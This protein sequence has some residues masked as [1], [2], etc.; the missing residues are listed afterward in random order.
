MAPSALTDLDLAVDFFERGAQLSPR[1]K[2][3]LVRS[4]SASRPPSP[5]SRSSIFI[6]NAQLW[7]T[8]RDPT[9]D[10]LM[11]FASLFQPILRNLKERALRAFNQYRN[12]H[13][14]PSLDIQLRIGPEDDFQDE[15]AIFGGQTRVVTN[16]FLSRKK[17]RI[18]AKPREASATTVPLS[19]PATSAAST[20]AP[21]GASQ[22]QSAA[23]PALT[24]STPSD[25]GLPLPQNVEEQMSNVH[26]SLMEYLSLFPADAS[27]SVMDVDPAPPS[28]STAGSHPH[29]DSTTSMFGTAQTAPSSMFST[30]PS[31][32]HGQP[33]VGVS[34]PQ[35]QAGPSALQPPPPVDPL[36]FLNVLPDGL[37]PAGPIA[38]PSLFFAASPEVSTGIFDASSFAPGELGEQWN[39]LMRETGFFNS[40]AANG[41][42]P[43][44]DPFAKFQEDVYPRY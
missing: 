31:H 25:D 15:L 17:A 23:T 29:H 14:A 43:G 3:A 34:V 10:V 13:M 20:P 16:K 38:D 37:N 26:P 12:R 5:A 42:A 39:S 19:P 36:H 41:A 22:S 11:T 18:Y 8:T 32:P 9:C 21:G 7:G 33:M 30:P 2:Q 40:Q 24:A 27:I 44:Q 6:P 28:L 1:A 4:T 35:T